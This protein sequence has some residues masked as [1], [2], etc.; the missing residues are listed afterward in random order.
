MKHARIVA[1]I[2]LA[3]FAHASAP[4]QAPKAAAARDWSRAVAATPEGGFRVGNPNATVKVVEYGSLTCGH[5]AHF[6]EEG[7]PKLL[8]DYVKTGRVSFEFRNYIRDPFDAVAALLSRCAGTGDYF[9][10]TDAMFAAQSQWIGKL[11]ALPAAER[12]RM[13]QLSPAEGFPQIAAASGLA[14]I[15]AKHGVTAAKAKT[16]LTDRARLETLLTLRQKAIE[17]YNLE[18]TPTF[19]INGKKVDA[20]G[21]ARLEPLLK[22][23]G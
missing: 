17:T 19:L 8:Q 11:Q 12:Q 9:A 5:C 10:A 22:P 16:C 15:A 23:G 7:Y 20:D 14:P 21:W 18:Y 3:A 6:A 1:A 13:V 2:G 4:A